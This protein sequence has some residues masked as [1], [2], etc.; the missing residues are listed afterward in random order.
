MFSI[1]LRV[2]GL[3]ILALALVLAVLDITRTISASAPVLTPLNELWQNISA[4]SL[5]WLQTSATNIHALL[6]DPV[7]LFVLQLPGWLV[8]FL[9]AML[10]MW[11]GQPADDRFGRFASR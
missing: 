9:L 7:L 11:A 5:E 6:W 3:A 4:A 1:L 8:F 10:M 2:V